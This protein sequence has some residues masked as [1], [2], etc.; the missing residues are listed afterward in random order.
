MERLKLTQKGEDSDLED[1]EVFDLDFSFGFLVPL[2]RNY[3]SA[4]EEDSEVD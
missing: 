1:R 2:H 3:A 4:C